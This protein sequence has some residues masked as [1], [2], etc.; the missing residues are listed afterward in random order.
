MID[1]IV[2]NEG[3]ESLI[4]VSIEMA[5]R[6]AA[7]VAAGTRDV[8]Q[9]TFNINSPPNQAFD[10]FVAPR[11]TS[12][13]F[14]S[15]RMPVDGSVEA[16]DF[17]THGGKSIL[18]EAWVV[19]ASADTLG[20]EGLQLPT[21][22]NTD[23]AEWASLGVGP[24]DPL[25]LLGAE[26]ASI[27]ALQA[28]IHTALRERRRTTRERVL[29]AI[30][31]DE[32]DGGPRLSRDQLLPPA[33]ASWRFRAG[34]NLTVIAFLNRKVSIE[35]SSAMLHAVWVP[36]VSFD[37]SDVLLFENGSGVLS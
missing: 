24:L 27:H 11:G 5:V 22:P 15:W 28:R 3:L 33:C 25:P 20:L 31:P 32:E 9:L 1:G 34:D 21:R 13:H 17:H 23:P 16:H 19:S 29:C 37:N 18:V 35:D 6:F 2:I 36:V 30:T 12:V 8:I 14:A 7:Q 10:T 4:N 26:L